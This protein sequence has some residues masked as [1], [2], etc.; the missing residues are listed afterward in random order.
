MEETTGLVRDA[1][2]GYGAPS[3]P[4]SP[5]Q[6]AFAQLA[7]VGAAG[8]SDTELLMLLLNAGPSGR[9]GRAT[10]ERLLSHFVSLV[11]LLQAEPAELAAVAGVT[12]LVGARVRLARELVRRSLLEQA[13]HVD[14]MAS[15]DLIR[16]FL[17]LTLT[18]RER[19]FFLGVFLDNN[20]R[21]IATEELFAGTLT[22]TS[23][24][25][26]EVVRSALRHN[27]AAFCCAHNHPSGTANRSEADRA[28]TT[29]LRHTLALVDV[30]LLDHFI[31]TDH[32]IVSFAES[33]WL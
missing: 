2:H 23:V 28:L 17:R 22:Q 7:G 4:H 19:E 16:D 10:A 6:A 15:P 26:R 27:A 1:G 30:R 11:R 32:A 13:R 14:A 18:G 33:G 24:H 8:L 3:T 20:H 9:G 12:P 29:A 31:V 5:A 25:P 21:V